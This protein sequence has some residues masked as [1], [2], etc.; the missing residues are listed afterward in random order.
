MTLPEDQE[1]FSNLFM[2]K[3]QINRA[4]G[5][6]LTQSNVSASDEMRNKSRNESNNTS[7]NDK[8]KENIKLRTTTGERTSFVL[9]KE[10]YIYSHS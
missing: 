10:I 2:N 8:K 5:Q 7:D 6:K 4:A 3:K 1:R 9:G